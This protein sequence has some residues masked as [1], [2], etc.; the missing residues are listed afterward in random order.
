MRVFIVRHGTSIAHET[1]VRQS[2]DSPLSTKGRKQAKAVG[3][4]IKRWRV[5]F[6]K[7]FT[8]KLP[9]AKETAEIISKILKTPIEEFEGI[10][11]KEQHPDLYGADIKSKVHHQSVAAYA[12][13]GRDMDYKFLGQGESIREVA[14]RA[15]AFR[16]HLLKSHLKEDILVVSHG[17]FIR[18]FVAVCVLGQDTG[19]T[20]FSDLVASIMISNTGVSMLEYDEELK[21]W[22]IVYL[23]NF[24]HLKGI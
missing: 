12:E 21:S 18:A 23:N 17:I 5:S 3:Q 6:E 19:D 14:Q 11:E 15:S 9:R 2:P 16:D 22:K 4:R 7:I 1:G 10:H 24:S 13:H 20:S 8:S